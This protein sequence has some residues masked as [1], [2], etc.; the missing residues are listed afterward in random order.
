MYAHSEGYLDRLWPKHQH[1]GWLYACWTWR[2][3]CNL[4]PLTAVGASLPGCG[5]HPIFVSA[6]GTERRWAVQVSESLVRH[7]GGHCGNLLTVINKSSFQCV[8]LQWSIGMQRWSPGHQHRGGR[9]WVEPRAG[10]SL[11]RGCRCVECVWISRE[12]AAYFSARFHLDEVLLV[13]CQAGEGEAGGVGKHSGDEL[14][15]LVDVVVRKV[16]IRAWGRR[17]GNGG[18]SRVDLIQHWWVYRFRA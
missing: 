8:A 10:Y 5:N 3:S 16:A 11:W 6:P 1:F 13:G 18:I 12:G 2:S 9:V 4:F 7:H 15:V 17:P 14:A